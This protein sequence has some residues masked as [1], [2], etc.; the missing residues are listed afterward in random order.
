METVLQ[1]RGNKSTGDN[2]EGVTIA[3]V[4]LACLVSSIASQAG[5]G[6]VPAFRIPS[7]RLQSVY[8]M[9]LVLLLGILA[10]IVSSAFV[11]SSQVGILHC[12]CM[13]CINR[14][15]GISSVLAVIGGFAYK[16]AYL[17]WQAQVSWT[18]IVHVA[19]HGTCI[20]GHAAQPFSDCMYSNSLGLYRYTCQLTANIDEG[21]KQ[22]KQHD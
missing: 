3:A 18:E 6:A 4:L 10:G 1:K 13:H 8:E 20:A 7:Y 9:P 11:Y 12:P 15:D 5:L 16:Q 17:E 19:P 14:T 21:G 22:L 2:S